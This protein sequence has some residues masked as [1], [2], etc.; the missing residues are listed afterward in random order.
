MSGAARAVSRDRMEFPKGGAKPRVEHF[1]PTGDA[2]VDS[3]AL[4]P[5]DPRSKRYF[6]ERDLTFP[7]ELVSS[8]HQ[9]STDRPI[10]HSVV[11][12]KH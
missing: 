10:A 1:H 9:P 6:V 3:T 2:P 11:Q 7:D 4:G 8:F 5:M 12:K